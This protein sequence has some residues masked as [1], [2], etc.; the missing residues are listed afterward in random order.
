M[1]LFYALPNDVQQSEIIIRDQEALH[2]TKVLRFKNGDLIHVTDGHGNLYHCEIR[3]LQK[4]QVTLSIVDK[5]TELRSDPFITLC[6]G[7]IKKR[8][9]MEFAVE[10]ATELGV[11]RIIIFNAD[12]SQ[13]EN[14]RKDRI[15][16]TVLSAMKQ[17]GRLFLPDIIIEESLKGVLHHHNGE[18]LLMTDETTDTLPNKNLDGRPLFIMVGPEGGY[19]Q[20]ERKILKE[21]K[22]L[23]IS[24]GNKRLRTETAA[25]IV[26]DR[27]KTPL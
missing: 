5:K 18:Q 2:I 19:S 22:A 23:P 12:H 24:L 27:F 25:I 26:I 16:S 9:R 20:N 8:D 10:K 14:I 13:K 6:I 1:N 3:N 11:D 15:H 17:S 4:S 21:K 7:N